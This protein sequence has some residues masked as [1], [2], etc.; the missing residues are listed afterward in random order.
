MTFNPSPA[1][2]RGDYDVAIVGMGPVGATLANL[3]ALRDLQVLIVDREPEIY[4]LPRAVQFDGECMRVF[5]TI[6]IADEML[7]DLLV[8]PGMRFVDSSGNI[9]V[10]WTRPTGLGPHGWPASYRFHHRARRG[11]RRRHRRRAR[12]GEICDAG[13]QIGTRVA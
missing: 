7:P 8:V 6:G 9:I 2:L 4:A 12:A 10:D 11:S 3:L 13:A 1:A 5:Q